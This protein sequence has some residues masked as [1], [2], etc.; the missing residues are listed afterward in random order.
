MDAVVVAEIA[1]DPNPVHRRINLAREGRQYG[2]IVRDGRRLIFGHYFP[3]NDPRPREAG[4]RRHLFS[5]CGAAPNWFDAEY[6]VSSERL[7]LLEFKDSY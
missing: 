3:R 6:D 2:G 5:V 4:W 1:G 7:T